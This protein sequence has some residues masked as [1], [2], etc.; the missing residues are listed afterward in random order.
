MA[1]LGSVYRSFFTD[2]AFK[3][4]GLGKLIDSHLGIRIK[5][6]GYQYI[7]LCF[8]KWLSLFGQFV[9]FV[10]GFAASQSNLLKTPFTVIVQAF[11][12][13]KVAL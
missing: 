1:T 13:L 7:G 5:H 6:Y 2:E 11:V 12:I 10:I 9:F 8:Q 4:V 3:R